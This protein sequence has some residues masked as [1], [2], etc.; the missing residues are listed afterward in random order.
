[1]NQLVDDLWKVYRVARYCAHHRPRLENIARRMMYLRQKDY[2]P[3]AVEPIPVAPAATVITPGCERSRSGWEYIG[4]GNLVFADLQ[5]MG[6]V[7]LPQFSFY[8]HQLAS[9]TPLADDDRF[10]MPTTIPPPTRNG[11]PMSYPN[12]FGPPPPPPHTASGPPPAIPHRYSAYD[13]FNNGA[14]FGNNGTVNPTASTTL[15]PHP[16]H[17]FDFGDVD[18]AFTTPVPLYVL[19]TDLGAMG[20]TVPAK[21]K[22]RL[23]KKLKPPT[24]CLNCGT[25]KTP[26]W[27]RSPQGEPLCNA[28]G[29]FLKLHGV[30]RPLSLKTDVIKK[31]QRRKDLV[32]KLKSSTNLKG[33]EWLI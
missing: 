25:S 1:M 20:E 33:L 7:C 8:D 9:S 5:Q 4:V 19:L 31:R 12:P 6:E 2:T 21:E 32:L 14:M 17:P 30:V 27:R 24:E 3:V 26:L 28:C 11:P 18:L 16:D 23:S 22:P 10:A 29:L 15:L 13:H